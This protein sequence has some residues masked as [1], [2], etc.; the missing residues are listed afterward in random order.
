M[1]KYLLLVLTI[2]IF[3]FAGAQ[4]YC[5]FDQ[6]QAKLERA[7]PAVKKAREEAEAKLMAMDIQKFLRE[8]GHGSN[9]GRAETIYEIPVVVHLMN[10]GTTPM[11]TDAEIITW[12]D[13]CNKFYSTTFGG[14]WY[15]T[16]QGGTVIPFKLVLAKRSPSCTATTGINQINVTATYPVY[17]TKGLNSSNSDGVSADQLRALSRWDPQSYY[18]IYVVNT[19]DSVALAQT[20]GLQGYASFPTNPDASYDTFM[21][22]SVVINTNDPTTLPHEFGH[23]LGLNHPFNTGSETACPTVTSG[24]CSADNDMVCDTPSTKSL[25]GVNPLPSNS[26]TNPCDAAGWNNVQYNVMNYTNSNRLFTQGQKDRGLAMFLQ[27]RKG[28]TT[29]LGGTAPSGNPTTLVAASCTPNASNTT[30]GNFNFGPTLVKIGT[31]DN[32]SEGSSVSNGNKTYYDYSALTCSNT[33]YSTNLSLSQNPQTIS[34][35]CLT[36]QNTFNVY[37]DYNNDG[38]FN[39]TNEKV[40]TSFVVA[41]NATGNTTFTI[42]SSGV[43]LNTTLRMRVVAGYVNYMSCSQNVQYGQIED[44]AVNISSATLAVSNEVANDKKVSIYPNPSKDGVFSI[45]LNDASSNEVKVEIVDM[46]GRV[47]YQTK[48]LVNNKTLNINSKLTKGT[49]IV[50]VNSGS[51]VSTEKLII[52]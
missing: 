29:S 5:A 15:T 18:N 43:T 47:V 40:V 1:K 17:S 3:S 20:G 6:N 50:K 39:E 49:Y 27:S 26:D 28:L 14:A 32:A 9:L 36:N 11:R 38:V 10:D 30:T 21:K 35:A 23:S 41:A 45:K 37:I 19:F 25:L 16:A 42:P 51:N 24:G 4:E 2:L 46:A 22:K 13:N 31:I 7:D 8:N 12:I 44:Y 33:K 52:K 34:L 48:G